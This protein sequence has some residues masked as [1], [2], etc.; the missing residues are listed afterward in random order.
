M[1]FPT[2]EPHYEMVRD[3]K[4]NGSS[5]NEISLTLASIGVEK[6]ASVANIKNV[7]EVWTGEPNMGE[8][9]NPST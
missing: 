8:D 6:G 7:S 9:Y 4:Q 3:M 1:S 2:L 5:Y